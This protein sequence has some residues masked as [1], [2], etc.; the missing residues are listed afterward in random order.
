MW[1]NDVVHS[2]DVNIPWLWLANQ[3]TTKYDNEANLSPTNLGDI[4]ADNGY[5]FVGLMFVT[6]LISASRIVC[7]HHS[8]YKMS[9]TEHM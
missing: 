6:V 9:K 4:Q 3:V 7:G 2:L 1:S 8:T 5:D